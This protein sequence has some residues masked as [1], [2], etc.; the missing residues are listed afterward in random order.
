MVM[1]W[2][3]SAA[4]DSGH[5]TV[6]TGDSQ[7]GPN[8]NQGQ[9]PSSRVLLRSTRVATRISIQPEQWTA[10]SGDIGHASVQQSGVL[11]L[12]RHVQQS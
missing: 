7:P 8:L 1:E 5:T 12:S 6:K 2:G 3:R 10:E 11:V 4:R 9:D